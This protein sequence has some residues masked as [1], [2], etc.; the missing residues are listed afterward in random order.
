MTT[1]A[2]RPHAGVNFPPPFVYVAGVLAGWLLNRR[3]R[4]PVTGG[5]SSVREALA[6]VLMVAWLAIS[7]AAFAAF[8]RQRTT[9]IPNRPAS[10]VVT[11][12]PYRYTRNPMY[13][14]L[15][16]LYLALALLMNTWWPIILLPVVI[17]VIDRA[18]IAREERYLSSA[19]PDAYGPYSARVRRWV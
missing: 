15:I 3:W 6:V 10:A 11:D 16:A 18:V 8:R 14:S 13:V 19:F 4:L 1:P 7:V 17:L 12:G 5:G 2:P 9:I